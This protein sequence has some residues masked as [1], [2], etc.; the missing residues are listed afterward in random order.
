MNK[1]KAFVLAALVGFGVFLFV[2]WAAS[3]LRDNSGPGKSTGGTTTTTTTSPTSSAADALC[4]MQC[5]GKS[6]SFTYYRDT[7][8]DVM[9][10]WQHSVGNEGVALTV[11]PDPATGL[12]LTYARYLELLSTQTSF[13]TEVTQNEGP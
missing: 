9:Y 1:T 6:G 7:I 4:N 11:M 12:P 5:I 10:L 8:T 13:Q 2:S 3:S